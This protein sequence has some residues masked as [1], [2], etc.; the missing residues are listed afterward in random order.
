M[1]ERADQSVMVR[2]RLRAQSRSL[3]RRRCHTGLPGTRAGAESAMRSCTRWHIRA[4]AGPALPQFPGS[5]PE[6]CSARR[7]AA[8]RAPG[9]QVVSAQPG[10]ACSPNCIDSSWPVGSAAS[11]SWARAG[12]PAIPVQQAR[13]ARALRR[14]FCDGRWSPVTPAGPAPHRWHIGV[15]QR[16]AD[17]RQLSGCLPDKCD[18]IRRA[19]GGAECRSCVPRR[20]PRARWREKG[21]W[22]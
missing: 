2:L 8:H 7:A 22:R 21:K 16:V 15:E 20:P 19:Y 11:W 4:C 17:V 5:A 9:G 10:G 1:V 18:V 14:R 6:P 3:V 12:S 13:L